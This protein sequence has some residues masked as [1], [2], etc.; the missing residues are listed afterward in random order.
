MTAAMVPFP[1]ETAERPIDIRL[2]SPDRRFGIHLPKHCLKAMLDYATRDYPRETGGV[3]LGKYT[4]SMALAI[5]TE[6]SGPPEDSSK[7][8]SGF[9]RGVLGLQAMISRLWKEQQYYLGEWHVHPDGPPVPS[10]TDHDQMRAIAENSSYQ[11]PEPLLVIL[12]FSMESGPATWSAG[13]YVFPR[14]GT[15]IHLRDRELAGSST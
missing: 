6:V 8:R 14:R 12:S 7:E 11:C 1:S 15:L 5:V 2:F 4:P 9:W 13:S 3:L 10:T